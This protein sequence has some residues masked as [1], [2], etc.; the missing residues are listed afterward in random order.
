MSM[1]QNVLAKRMDK[2]YQKSM[3]ELSKNF[4]ILEDHM[5]QVQENQAETEKYLLEILDKLTKKEYE[6][7][8]TENI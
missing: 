2:E 1:I 5:I 7:E 8:N 6:R 4:K 3:T